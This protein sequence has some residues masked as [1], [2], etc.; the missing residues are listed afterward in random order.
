MAAP[1]GR[2]GQTTDPATEKWYYA[3]VVSLS[4]DFK[5]VTD[6]SQGGS[7]ASAQASPLEPSALEA[8]RQDPSRLNP[9][10]LDPSGLDPE[11]PS[12]N[13]LS[14]NPQAPLGQRLGHPTA[15]LLLLAPLGQL[16]GDGQL[17][18]LMKER[19]GHG[20]G[21]A[22]LWYLPPFLLVSLGLGRRDQEGLAALDPGVITWLQLRFGGV[23]KSASID[24]ASLAAK[25]QTLPAPPPLAALGSGGSGTRS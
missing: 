19:R 3:I 7:A 17:R 20:G 1:A 13:P 4:D 2:P 23:V 14:P 11:G 22:E 24:P 8:S 15:L 25:A 5:M 12:P 21:D 9:G 16:S 18:E 10:Q 6:R